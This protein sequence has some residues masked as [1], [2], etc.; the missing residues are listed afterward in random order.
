MLGLPR[1]EHDFQHV[2]YAAD[3][4]DATLGAAGPHAVSGPLQWRPRPSI[5]PP[6]P[7]NRFANDNFWLHPQPRLDHIPKILRLDL[8]PLP[9]E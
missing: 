4:F 5:L 3:A 8:P 9:R 1:F 7:F 2:S 6:D